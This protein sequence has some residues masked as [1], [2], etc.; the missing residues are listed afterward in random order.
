MRLCGFCLDEPGPCAHPECPFGAED[1]IG[2]EGALP[3]RPATRP[4]IVGG[5]AAAVVPSLAH[6][7]NTRAPHIATAPSIVSE[8]DARRSP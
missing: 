6:G 4:S 7:A 2:D 3:P 8:R 5:P 1:T